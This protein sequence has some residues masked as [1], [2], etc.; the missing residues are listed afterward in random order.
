MKRCGPQ[1]KLKHRNVGDAA[2]FIKPG[3]AMRPYRCPDCGY[4][5]LTRELKTR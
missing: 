1:K 5:H 4:W 2:R 3:D